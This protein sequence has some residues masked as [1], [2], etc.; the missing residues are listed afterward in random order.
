[1]ANEE[2]LARLKQGVEA[3]NQ[4]RAAHRDIR[5]DLR[6]ASL[7]D[8]N[9]S[10]ANLSRA[11]LEGAYLIKADLSQA[12]LIKTDFFQA[13]LTQAHLSEAKLF[14]ANFIGAHLTQANFFRA[15]LT[16]ADFSYAFLHEAN[17][18]RT[19]LFGAR[20][21][22]AD[23]CGA[24]VCCADLRQA[25]F[26]N[27]Q[28][29]ETNFKNANLTGCR[30]YGISAWNVKREGAQQSDL[31]I[32]PYHEPRITVDDLEVAQFIYLLLN[33]QKIR[34]V[35]NTITSKMVLILGRFT[36]ER[37]KVL[38]AIRMELRRRN[39]LPVL[40]D[41][42]KP[43]SRDLT[44]TISTLAHMA[45]FIITDITYAKSIPQELERIV[46]GLPSVP[47][48]PLLHISASEYGMFEHFTRYPWVLKIYQYSRLFQYLLVGIVPRS[49]L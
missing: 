1:M 12:N 4:W 27:A 30:V 14:R 44:E 36:S 45:R 13:H 18:S 39:Y 15:R 6:G 5:P 42:E 7:N 19:M 29:V 34:D 9:L 2:H 17:L 24:K 48:Q 23:L 38:D 26:H 28:L 46:P 41:F 10:G 21:A 40:F 11:D 31:R 22:N 33:N 49:I 37:K 25:H 47:I 8:K 20:F 3:W 43:A 16:M 35:I 32:T